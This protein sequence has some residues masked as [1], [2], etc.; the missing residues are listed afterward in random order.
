MHKRLEENEINRILEGLKE[1]T[2][3]FLC[4]LI[5]IPSTRGLEGPV[6]RLIYN[7]FLNI[8]DKAELM[9]IPESFTSDPEYCWPLENFQYNDSHNVRLIMNGTK[10]LESL[11]L[12]LNAHMD[13][14]PPSDKQTH[15]FNPQIQGDTI[16]GRG[17][18]DDK[19]QIAVIYMLITAMKKLNL[20]PRGN[21]IVDF[22]VEEENG[23][24]GTLFMTRHPFITDGAIVLEPTEM[25]ICAAVRGAVWF[26]LTCYGRAGHSGSPEKTI[27]ALKK[28]ILAM[29]AIENYHDQLLKESR[30]Q[31]PLFDNYDN[32]MPVTFGVLESGNWPA[33][34]PSKAVIKGVFGFLPNMHVKDVQKGI[35]E[36]VKN[37][38]DDWLAENF[39]IKYD[40]LNN[41]GNE[42]PVDHPLIE[43][44]RQTQIDIGL[45]GKISAMTAACD[46]W[47]YANK[48]NIPTVV[49]G[50]GSLKKF[51]H[52]VNEQISIEEI[53]DC[54]RTLF[55]FIEK[56]CGYERKEN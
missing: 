43:K 1:D 39:E 12:L 35:R 18:C 7:K 56:W 26:E 14:V 44:I 32:P 3:N 5:R 28:A 15:A 47:Q 16:L 30:G 27:S 38:G 31:N 21:I 52:T 13:V 50:A 48:L 42:L 23:G 11:S 6:A 33:T 24:N 2:V 53:M 29:Q 20:N 54:A 41:D 36:A 10:H 17:A 49:M 45:P 9:T 25:E 4:D 40:M 22:V 8:I 46:A 37:C 55:Y 34:T 19:G 51:A